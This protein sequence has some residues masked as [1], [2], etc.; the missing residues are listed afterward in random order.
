MRAA[1]LIALAVGCLA[2]GGCLSI[3]INPSAAPPPLPPG[4]GAPL[5]SDEQT[6]A[7]R[8]LFIAKCTGCH[9]FHPPANY[10][11]AEWNYWMAK[12]SRKAKLDAEQ[13]AWLRTYL[14]LFRQPAN[15]IGVNGQI[16]RT[17]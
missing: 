16:I 11:A 14:D 12:M 15:P 8:Q 17:R 2:L 7:A 5:L 9:K 4:S 1:L 6:S 13:E 10:N 3:R